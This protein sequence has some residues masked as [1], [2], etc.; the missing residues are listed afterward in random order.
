M[1]HE[2]NRNTR[3][4]YSLNCDEATVELLGAIDE[5]TESGFVYSIFGKKSGHITGGL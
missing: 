4:T 1:N 3:A 2:Y 5:R